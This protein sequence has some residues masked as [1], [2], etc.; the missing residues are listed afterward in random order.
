MQATLEFVSGY[1]GQQVNRLDLTQP[2]PSRCTLS[3]LAS[4]QGRCIPSYD[5]DRVAQTHTVEGGEPLRQLAR[6][7]RTPLFEPS[8]ALSALSPETQR[9]L[10]QLQ[11]V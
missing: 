1:V 2:S 3:A 5:L 9:D 7:L 6:R 11:T 4:L 10:R 8:G